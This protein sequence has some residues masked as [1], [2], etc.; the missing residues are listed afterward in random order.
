MIISSTTKAV[1]AT[2]EISSFHMS[3]TIDKHDKLL[4]HTTTG[5]S[6]LDYILTSII[7]LYSPACSELVAYLNF[8]FQE[9]FFL[10][11]LSE[12]FKKPG[13]NSS[14]PSNHRPISNLSN[15]SKMLERP[16]L[17][18]LH[19]L[20]TSSPTFNHLTHSTPAVPNCCCSKGP[21]PYWSNPPFLIFDIRAQS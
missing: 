9:R 14:F 16:F 15:I 3:M 11:L 8:T 20:A 5:S 1:A 18:R 10:H 12:V 19:P 2:L 7:K 4:V 17:T 21:A 13:L 6:P